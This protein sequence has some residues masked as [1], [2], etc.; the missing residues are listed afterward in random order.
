MESM[1]S[2]N[3]LYVETLVFIGVCFNCNFNCLINFEFNRRM[4]RLK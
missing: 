3:K 1:C 4:L 2:D